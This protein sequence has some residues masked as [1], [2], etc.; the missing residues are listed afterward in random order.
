MNEFDAKIIQSADLLLRHV[1]HSVPPHLSPQ[2]RHIQT[3][4]PGLK[5][6]ELATGKA[7]GHVVRAPARKPDSPMG[8]FSGLQRTDITPVPGGADYN[9]IDADMGRLSS[10][11]A[12][13][14]SQVVFLEHPGALFR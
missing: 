14:L 4:A 2:F 13:R 6:S 12:D 3:N 9:L 7:Q 5:G 8:F 11:P 10:H 1:H